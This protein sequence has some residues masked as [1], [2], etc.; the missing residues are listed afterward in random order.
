LTSDKASKTLSRRD[1]ILRFVDVPR[2]SGIEF[3]P[4]VSPVVRKADGNISYVDRASTEELRTCFAIDEKI[5]IME[6]MSI[7]YVWNDAPLLDCVQNNQFHYAIASHVIEH[8]PDIVTWLSEVS[9][10]LVDNG[11][12][13]L[14]I[15][16]K[17]YTF[18]CR[19]ELSTMSD[20]IDAYIRRLRK[21]SPRQI[22]D[23]FAGIADVDTAGLWS[24][25]LDPAQ[26]RM[27]HTPES[28]LQTVRKAY[29]ND[30]Y[31]DSHCWVVTPY[32][33]FKLL[34]GLNQLGLLNFEVA[35]FDQTEHN[36]IEFFVTLRRFERNS[37]A[38]RNESLFQQSVEEP[39]R[40]AAKQR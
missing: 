15:P 40:A 14:V 33:F 26:V 3:G 5:N 35:S 34:E 38:T 13:S 7:D 32:S 22:F 9:D 25:T 2:L 36:D 37:P 39:L 21:P 24:G 31:I 1:K 4:L 29:A 30:E 23:H 19:R 17:R 16:D 20:I 8:V 10:V 28:V 18:D 12:L 6:I 11:I 27:I